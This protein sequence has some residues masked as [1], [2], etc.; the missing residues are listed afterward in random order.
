MPIE[1]KTYSVPVVNIFGR[2]I[3]TQEFALREEQSHKQIS[4]SLMTPEQFYELDEMEQAEV[5]WD[6]FHIGKD[7]I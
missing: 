3:F 7:G 1:N 5:I 4:F 2:L 6:G